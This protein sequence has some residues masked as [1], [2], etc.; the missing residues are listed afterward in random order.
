LNNVVFPDPLGPINPVTLPLR[1]AIEQSQT[2]LIPPK[3][4]E[5]ASV[6]NIVAC[7]SFILWDFL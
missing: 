1:T 3:L 7:V 6:R 5:S 2:A 4:R